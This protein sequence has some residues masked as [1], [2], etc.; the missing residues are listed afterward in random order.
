MPRP[1]PIP[2]YKGRFICRLA[3]L[4]GGT[5]RGFSINVNDKTTTHESRAPNKHATL[6]LILWHYKGDIKGFINRCPHQNVPL[7]IIPDRFLTRNGKA[8]ICS[9]HGAQFDA[10]GFCFVGPCKGQSLRP[11]QLLI[12]QGDIFLA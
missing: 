8:L 5:A 7:E 9:A 2:A 3:D 11:V 12:K 1:L 6:E 4:A 10:S